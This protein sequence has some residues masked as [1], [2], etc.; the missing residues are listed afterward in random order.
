LLTGE[1]IAW[2]IRL[3]HEHDNLRAALRWAQDHSESETTL[4]IIGAL[5]R[6]WQTGN[7]VGEGRA[8]LYPALATDAL[9][10]A[11]VRA[12]AYH[13]AGA[14]ALYQDDMLEGYKLHEQGAMWANAACDDYLI[15]LTLNG[16]TSASRKAGDIVRT[17]PLLEQ[18]LVH[19][20]RDKNSTNYAFTLMQ[21]ARMVELQGDHALAMSLDGE[22]TALFLNAGDKIWAII[23]LLF[24]G[25]TAQSTGDNVQA[26]R[27]FTEGLIIAKEIGAEFAE[28]GLVCSHLSGLGGLAATQRRPMRMARLHGA[29]EG[30][31]ERVGD[32]GCV[33][34]PA[35]DRQT[36]ITQYTATGGP[37]DEP[38]FAVAWVEGRAMTL[39]QAIEYALDSDLDER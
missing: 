22:A 28:Y 18:A 13:A 37:V 15:G 8:W 27:Y 1:Q 32:I 26:E 4:R 35:I 34:I 30:L 39:E 24:L 21:K 16:L 14:L 23:P 12:K 7:R 36:A 29:V 10:P 5:W 3:S 6:Y 20:G 17:G 31:A 33:I 25:T 19:N 11:H 2:L 38:A 9:V